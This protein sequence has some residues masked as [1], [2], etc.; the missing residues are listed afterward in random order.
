M[1][2]KINERIAILEANKN[3]IYEQLK[4]LKNDIKDLQKVTNEA[5]RN[6]QKT[7]DLNQKKFSINNKLDD[8][9]QTSGK[10]YHYYK[11]LI[12]GALIT[13]FMSAVIGIIL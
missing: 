12:I 13:G 2:Q 10:D 5:L 6:V 3:N 7:E 1:D 9:E 8:I 11:R 4:E